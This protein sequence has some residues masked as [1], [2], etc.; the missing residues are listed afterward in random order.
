M[1]LQIH[2]APA[3]NLIQNLSISGAGGGTL[4]IKIKK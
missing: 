1:S 3:L 2:F 4:I